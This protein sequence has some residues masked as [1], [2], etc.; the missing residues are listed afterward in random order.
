MPR[1]RFS[2]ALRDNS[3]AQTGP[4]LMTPHRAVFSVA[5]DEALIRPDLAEMPATRA[6]RVVGEAGDGQEAVEL[7]EQLRPDLVIM[8]EDAAPRRHRRGLAEIAAKAD[9]AHRDP[10]RLQQRELVERARR[11]RHG[12]PG[13][14]FS[15]T[16]LVHIEVA[17]S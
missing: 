9:R 10:D 7:M 1:G 17:V 15:I 12:L 2:G 16:D 8:D 6:I 14:Q 4:Q 11:R 3:L 13:R 5:E